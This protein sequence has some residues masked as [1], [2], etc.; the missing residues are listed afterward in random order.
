MATQILNKGISRR[1]F[2]SGMVAASAA[3]VVGTSL[4]APR[5]AMAATETKANFSGEV[6]SGSHWGAFRAKVENGVWVDTVPFEKDKHP[7]TM[8]DG[9]REVVYNPARVK[10]PMVRLDWLKHGYKSDTTQRGDNRFVRVPWSQALDFFYHEMERIQNN[11]GPSALYAGHTGW[12]SVGKLHS[13]GTMMMRAIGLHGTFLAKMGDYSTGAAQV[14]LPYVAGAMEVYEQQTSWPLVL[15][16]SDT[17]VIWGSDPIKNLQVGWLVPDHSPY[18]YF[19]QLAEKVKNNEIKVIYVDPVVSDTQKFV[20]GEQV[21]V[22]PQTD[23]PLMLLSPIR[24]TPRTFTTKSSW[25]TTPQ[26]STSSCL[27]C[28]VKKTAHQKHRSGQRKSVALTQILSVNLL[29]RWLLAAP[30][31]SVAGVCSACS[32][33]SSTRGCWLLLPQCLVKLAYRAVASAS[34]GTITMQVQ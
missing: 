5:N 13:A 17:I 31:S 7:T 9:V 20:G 21:K 23:V 14:V 19:D 29:V 22:N 8:I 15:E 34:A 11:Y 33:V 3:S 32:M 24:F 28:L 27:T 16:H 6:L 4:L 26:A 1:R 25:L 30:R 12:Q 10:Y 18:A 2:L